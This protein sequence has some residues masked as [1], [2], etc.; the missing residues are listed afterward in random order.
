MNAGI[1][2]G[3]Q[4]RVTLLRRYDTAVNFQMYLCHGLPSLAAAD[5]AEAARC[6]A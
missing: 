3:G 1:A 6:H 4:N 2:G 5:C